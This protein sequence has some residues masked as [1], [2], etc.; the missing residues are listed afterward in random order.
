VPVRVVTD[1]TAAL[2]RDVAASR[3]ITL[4]P[5]RVNVGD[6]S[7]LDGEVSLPELIER[8]G[9]GLRTSGPPPGAFIDAVADAPDGV[10]VV[11]VASNLSSTFTSAGVALGNAGP[12][13]RLVDS[14]TAA[15][16]QALVA[17]HA[18]AVA[19]TGAGIDEVERAARHA[20]GRVRLFGALETLEFLVR[21]G[22][23]N[24][25]I[26]TLADTL[27]V[28]PVF[29]L[30][31]GVIRR[32]RPAFSRAAAMGRLLDAWRESEIP[33][34]RPHCIALHAL[35][36]DHAEE[37]LARVCAEREP[38]TAL[39]SEF[40]AGMVAHTGPGLIGLSWWWEE[41]EA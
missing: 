24:D 25:F 33:G 13:A 11:T 5:I 21:G 36:Q 38:A 15:G 28:R 29:E 26:G 18:A 19:A 4:V 40:G 32:H 12:E 6:Q 35:A 37:L 34:A 8:A 20:A 22:R 27:G 30:R 41:D 23:V 7:Y 10:V 31:E 1:T 9:E 39:V 14:G 3:D 17:L 16:A 2:D